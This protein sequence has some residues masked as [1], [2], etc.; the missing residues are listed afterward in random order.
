MGARHGARIDR[1]FASDR[2]EGII[3]ALEA[4]P[5]DWAAKE[6]ATLRTKSPLACKVALRLLVESPKCAH[7]LDEMKLEFD[8]VAHMFR[9]PDFGEGVRAI[10]IEKDN[11]PRWHP[12]TPEA[13][14][15]ALID[16]IFAP[17]PL[18]EAWTPLPE[19][20]GR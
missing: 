3:A 13:V 12:A 14:T 11:A 17:L 4:D 19:L 16:S 8:I 2:L 15:E 6:L 20:Q 18:R 10:L 9:H 1:L 5:S 7:F